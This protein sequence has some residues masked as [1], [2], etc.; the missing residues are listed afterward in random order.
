MRKKYVFFLYASSLFSR[1]IMSDQPGQLNSEKRSFCQ[2]LRSGWFSQDPDPTFKK[3]T[4]SGSDLPEKSGSDP[5]KQNP[6]SALVKKK[7][8]VISFD[9]RSYI[10]TY[11]LTC[12]KTIQ[13]KTNS[14][15]N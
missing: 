6:D 1:Y 5:R 13:Y 8:V 9:I 12:I 7:P 14:F 15:S 2:G 10:Y 11:I 4:G 3:K